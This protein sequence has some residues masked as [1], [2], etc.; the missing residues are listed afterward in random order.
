[1][2]IWEKKE[3]GGWD[4]SGTTFCGCLWD[5]C[6]LRGKVEHVSTAFGVDAYTKGRRS[7]TFLRLSKGSLAGR[8][9]PHMFSW[10]WPRTWK[11]LHSEVSLHTEETS[12]GFRP[13]SEQLP[14]SGIA[15]L[16]SWQSVSLRLLFHVTMTSRT[17]PLS[18]RLTKGKDPTVQ[19]VSTTIP[20]KA[21]ATAP[22]TGIVALRSVSRPVASII[23]FWVQSKS[24]LMNADIKSF[25]QSLWLCWTHVPPYG[26]RKRFLEMYFVRFTS[27]P[28]C[29]TKRERKSKTCL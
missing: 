17:C 18:P 27:M 25:A 28:S 19:S 2:R 7:H 15:P 1:M 24:R 11:E 3:D 9:S 29:T 8:A 14:I 6:E 5:L 26:R 12:C 16:S 23:S 22:A 4:V 13:L 21:Y 10:S 20:P